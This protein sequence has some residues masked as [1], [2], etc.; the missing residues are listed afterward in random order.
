[1]AP[2]IKPL[3]AKIVLSRD[4]LPNL[5]LEYAQMIATQNTL[6]LCGCTWVVH[7]DDVLL[8]TGQR[9]IRKGEEEP[10]CPLHTKEG[11]ALYFIPWALEQMN[12][13]D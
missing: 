6:D 8:P 12:N 2:N 4:E 3:P 9:R 13:N 11:F 5:A 7:P 10:F 1:M